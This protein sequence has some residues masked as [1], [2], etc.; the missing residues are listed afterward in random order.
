MTLETFTPEAFGA[1]LQRDYTITP[2]FNVSEDE[3]EI[4]GSKSFAVAAK[5]L[6]RLEGLVY[7]CVDRAPYE[8]MAS[9]FQRHVGP[10]G[11]FLYTWPEFVATPDAAPTMEAV[12]A[13]AQS[14]RTIFCKFAWKTVFGTTRASPAASLTV[15][16]NSLLKVTLPFFPT[17]VLEAVIYATEGAEGTEQE[18]TEISVRTWTQPDGALLTATADPPTE[19]TAREQPICKLLGNSFRPQRVSGPRYVITLDLEETY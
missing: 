2:I 3:R 9:F 8:Y 14:S 6:R 7:K 17:S 18:Q 15:P 19:N 5:A 1:L 11:R 13:G 10:A 4:G 12:V 16:S